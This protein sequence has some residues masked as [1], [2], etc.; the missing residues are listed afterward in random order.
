VV[1]NHSISV[2]FSPLLATNGTP[3]WW[4]AQFGWTNNFNAAET[5]DADYDGMLTWQEWIAGTD[6]IDRWSVLSVTNLRPSASGFVL[7]WFSVS[8]RLYGVDRTTNLIMPGFEG[9]AT[10][11]PAMP[12]VNVYTDQ[13][14]G[15]EKA[16]YRIKVE[17]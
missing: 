1:T 10:N 4:L 16:F 6:P 15:I 11:L 8:N 5:S 2:R 7:H 13:A 14:P 9:I 3:K 12:P 17:Q